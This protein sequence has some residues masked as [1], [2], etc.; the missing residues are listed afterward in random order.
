MTEKNERR[1]F[2]RFTVTD[3]AFAFIHNT[4]FIIQNI[5]KGGMQLKSVVFDETLPDDILLDIFLKDDNF[6]LQN[7]PVRLVRFHKNSAFSPF[8]N[9]HV[10]FFGLQFGELTEQQKSRLDYFIARS[11]SGEA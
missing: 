7:I 8:S 2:T 5:S 9:T 3:G 1:L 6:Y 11:T 10:R 4:P